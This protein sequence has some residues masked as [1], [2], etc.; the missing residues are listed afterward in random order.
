MRHYQRKKDNP[1]QL[2]H[3]VYM[4]CLYLIRDY[5]RLRKMLHSVAVNESQ[6]KVIELR[7]EAIEQALVVVPPEYHSGVLDNIMY[8]C[9]YPID[10][11]H[12]TYGNWR[13]RF[14]YQLAVNMKML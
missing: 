9:G 4:Q 1:Y 12:T 7:C 13:R 3:N 5:D 11:S 10:A 2:P 6:T 8:G 14:I